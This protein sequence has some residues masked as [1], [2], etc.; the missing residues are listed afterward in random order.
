V[1]T[2]AELVT[3]EV[4]HARLRPRPHRLSYR[5]F[6][7]LLDVDEIDAVAARCRLFSRNRWNVVSFHDADYGARD[8]RPVAEQARE[9]F[10]NAGLEDATAR[11]ELLA[12]PRVLG[13]VFN[14]LTVYFGYDRRG[15]LIG[16]IYEVTNTFG[17][18]TSY[19]V[20]PGVA[21]DGVYAHGC[22]KEMYVSPFT[23]AAGRYAFRVRPPAGG[24]VL[25][26][27]ALHD[28]EGALLR[29]HF[30]GRPEPFDDRHLLTALARHPLMTLK[31][32]TAIHWEALRLYAKGVP[33]VRRHR[34]PR[35][36]VS[37]GPASRR[38]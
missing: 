7:V 10:R 21:H 38:V 19:V 20:E 13:Y 29:T 16:L 9:N 25:V 32:I 14:P 5:V 26:G 17:E 33:V 27:V 15:E 31:V 24:D 28:G 1:S 4:V 36:S 22:G 12:Y 8:G 2:G 18:R 6:S 34:S 30:R 37:W 3:G 23:P 35:Y 11:I